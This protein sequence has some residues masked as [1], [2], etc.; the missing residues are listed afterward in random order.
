MRLSEDEQYVYLLSVALSKNKTAKF[1][2]RF[3]LK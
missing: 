1:I 2:V 3:F